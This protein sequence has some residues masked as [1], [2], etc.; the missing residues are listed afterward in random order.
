ME[1]LFSTPSARNPAT[2]ARIEIG[3]NSHSAMPRYRFVRDAKIFDALAGLNEEGEVNWRNG[4]DT[5]RLFPMHVTGN[6]FEIVGVPVAKGRPIVTGDDNVVVLSD[7]LW[8]IRLGGDPEILGRA[9]VLDGKPYT[10]V[11]VLAP[12]HRTLTG[13]GF[14]PDLYM[15]VPPNDDKAIVAFIARLPHGMPKKVAMDRLRALGSIYPGGKDHWPTAYRIDAVTGFERLNLLGFL[16]FAAFFGMLLTVVGLVLL[17]ACINVASL[18]LARAAGRQQELAIRLAIGASRSRVVRQLLTESSLLAVFGTA[19]GL[20]FNL[21]STH[22]INSTPLPLPLPIRLNIHPDARLLLYAAALAVFSAVLSGLLPAL[23]ATRVGANLALK[24]AA[25]EVSAGGWKMR[26]GLVAGQLALSTML[27]GTGLLFLNNLIRASSMNPGFD[28]EHT[29]WAAVRLVPSRYPTAEKRLALAAMALD[30]LRTLPAIEAASIASQVPLNNVS[31]SGSDMR[32]D[33]DDRLQNVG[34]RPNVVGPDYFRTMGIPLLAGREFL[35]SDRKGSPEV[36]IL[37]EA[38]AHRCFGN[39][40]P[41]GH[42]IRYGDGAPIEIIGIAKNSKY[43]TPGE[44]KELALYS[45][46]LQDTQAG[47]D[48]NFMIR[49]SGPPEGVIKAVN[50]TL[51]DLDPTA[52]IEV[53]LMRNSLGFALLPSRVGAAVLGSMGLLGLA[54]ASIGLYGVLAYAVSRRLREIGLRMALGARP[55]DILRMVARQSLFLWSA[56]VVIGTGLALLATK[57]LA[58]FLVPELSPADPATFLAA[59]AVLGVVAALATLGLALRALRVDP[60]TALRWE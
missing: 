18:L 32:T 33:L 46:T 35:P 31:S 59:I 39:L 13:F 37:N 8:R 6:F 60:V 43:V 28:V 25:H 44:G 23:R 16:P 29:V 57:P 54:L 26:N 2:L 52:A 15:P 10:V 51:G 30:Q 45:P 58:M 34:Y 24:S 38:F 17:I 36:V 1:F 4:D 41:V 56:G 7:R 11:G 40:N 3:G 14:H 50:T 12:D 20:L 47:V 9:L 49:A 5:Y 53:K 21:W 22:F 19:A 42:T 27:L 55:S 48:F